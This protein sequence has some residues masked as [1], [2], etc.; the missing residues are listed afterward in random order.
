MG[1]DSAAF[2]A[3]IE[4]GEIVAEETSGNDRLE[5]IKSKGTPVKMDL[6]LE[7]SKG[8]EI[9]VYS[10]GDFTKNDPSPTSARIRD[11]GVG[12]DKICKMVNSQKGNSYTLLDVLGKDTTAGKY[13]SAF[14]VQRVPCAGSDLI[15]VIDG[16][17][18]F[19]GLVTANYTNKKVLCQPPGS[20]KVLVGL[21][22]DKPVYFGDT[23]KKEDMGGT[24]DGGKGDKS[25]GYS[26]DHTCGPKLFHV[27]VVP[28]KEGDRGRIVI[29]DSPT[30][31]QSHTYQYLFGK[32]FDE[33]NY[34][35]EL[36]RLY[37]AESGVT[38][39]CLKYLVSRVREELLAQE[40][41][42][43]ASDNKSGDAD[44]KSGG[45][46]ANG[47][48]DGSKKSGKD[49][50]KPATD[51]KKDGDKDSKA[52]AKRP[53]RMVLDSAKTVMI[54]PEYSTKTVTN[55][56]RIHVRV[57]IS[58]EY[59]TTLAADTLRFS[60]ADTTP[61][62]NK[63]KI[64]NAV[65]PIDQ[66]EWEEAENDNGGFFDV[67]LL[68]NTSSLTDTLETVQKNYIV[69]N[70]DLL[71]LQEVQVRA[72]NPNKP[73]WIELGANFD[74]LDKLQTNNLYGAVVLHK[75]D[76]AKWMGK[77][78]ISL[79]GGVYEAKTVSSEQA[80]NYANFQYLDN[81]DYALPTNI[82]DKNYLIRRDTGTITRSTS[83]IS[84]GLFISP[85]LRL[86]NGSADANGLHVFASIWL[87]MIWQRATTTF[88]YSKTGHLDSF[89]I[90]ATPTNY[91]VYSYK[92]TTLQ[93]DFRSHFFGVGLPLYLKEGN[94][95]LY[96]NS[97]VGISNQPGLYYYVPV[98]D[99]L[100]IR[101]NRFFQP[102]RYNLR[103]DIT[104]RPFYLFQFRL[105]EEKYG[106]SFTG[107]VRGTM[108]RDYKPYVTLAL[109]KKFDLSKMLE[110]K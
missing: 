48:S 76:V 94:A 34:L 42:S 78:N 39:D 103:G 27:L 23:E 108:A 30:T 25:P 110:F 16:K 99:S 21:N 6:F 18:F 62:P 46:D 95:N 31:A 97:V 61:L 26:F 2:I 80:F 57:K 89:Y 41:E 15:K 43:A 45:T 36:T 53:G 47:S 14:L 51:S 3:A 56:R 83:V 81:R 71:H 64:L 65:I 87:E 68:V 67:P 55:N 82:S 37:G 90:P 102:V 59:D 28:Y 75:R 60:L 85:Q 11:L 104:W 7:A 50:K 105:N 35:S 12:L 96:V 93:G 107:E 8:K 9:T 84:L 79:F 52:K 22:K 13:F 74:L 109:S 100:D 10:L 29:T 24:G 19:P 72:Y 88:D 4:A 86:T 5:L 49:D 44:A 17:D 54:L 1:P 32:S 73:F 77:Q 101:T 69:L 20:N 58:G 38:P 91:G 33:V 106:I 92:P 63:L 40:L 98:R 66:Q 70:G